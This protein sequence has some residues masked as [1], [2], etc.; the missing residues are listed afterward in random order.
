MA[1]DKTM[2]P[3]DPNSMPSPS[4]GGGGMPPSAPADPMG[5]GS[6]VEI[7]LPKSAFD[8]MHQIIM[9]LAA[10]M[11]EL[12]QGIGQQGGGMPPEMG[13]MPT[14]MGAG[15]P[16]KG[17]PA[18]GAGGSPEDEEFLKSLMAEGNGKTM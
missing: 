10:G 3:N 9:Q 13:G 4:Y 1:T 7:R 15:M 11:D 18:V 12:A 17:G 8:A 2:P 5:G 14:E 16:P 6:D